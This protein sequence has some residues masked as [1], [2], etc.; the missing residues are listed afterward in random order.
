MSSLKM[1]MSSNSVEK[2]RESA[3]FTKY[4]VADPN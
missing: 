2:F 3:Y 1:K 4:I